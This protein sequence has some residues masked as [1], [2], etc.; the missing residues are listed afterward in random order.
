ML[1]V[2]I[3]IWEVFS[4]CFFK[5]F[6]PA[7]FSLFCFWNSITQMLE[8]LTLSYGS[9]RLCLPFFHLFSFCFSDMLISIDPSSVLWFF[10]LTSQ[11]CYWA[12]LLNFSFHYYTNHLLNFHLLLFYF[13][14]L[15]CIIVSLKFAKSNIWIHLGL[16]SV[17]GFFS[18]HVD[19]P[20]LFSY[21]STNFWLKIRPLRYCII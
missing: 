11:I 12:H 13:T 3:K 4:C 1:I 19:H 15:F 8:S 5:F 10:S 14:F 7:S 16:V 2:L 18:Q 21:T 17:D 6:L 20:L 9:L